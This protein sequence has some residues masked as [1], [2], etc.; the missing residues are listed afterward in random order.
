MSSISKQR[1][2]KNASFIISELIANGYNHF[3]IAPGSNS[4]PLTIAAHEHPLAKT[5]VHYDERSLGFFALGISKGGEKACVITTSGTA[6]CNLYPSIVEASQSNASLIILTAD[7]SYDLRDT[8]ANQTIDQVKMF[9]SYLRWETEISLSTGGLDEKVFRTTVDQACYRSR[10]GPVWINCPIQ[11]PGE[12]IDPDKDQSGRKPIAYTHYT[13]TEKA[14][15]EKSCIK[16]A[17][18][19]EK[20]E[21]GIIIVGAIEEAYDPLPILE[22]ATKLRWPVFADPTS[23]LRSIGSDLSKIDYYNFLIEAT[24]TGKEMKPRAVLHLGGPLVS[25]SLLEWLTSTDLKFYAQ[26]ADFP[27]RL[28]PFHKVSERIEM[29][30]ALFAKMLLP[31]LAEKELNRWAS[32]WKEYS[33]FTS[34]KIREYFEKEDHFCEANFIQ[35]LSEISMKQATLFLGASLPIRHTDQFFFPCKWMGGIFSNR[36]T[37]GI[38]GNLSTAAGIAIATKTHMTAVVGDLTFL[39]DVGALSLIRRYQIPLTVIVFNNAGGGIFEFLPIQKREEYFTNYYVDFPEESIEEIA[40]SYQILS[41]SADSLHAFETLLSEAHSL[42]AP[43]VIEIKTDRRESPE[44]YQDIREYLR[45]ALQKEEL[46]K[47]PWYFKKI[48]KKAPEETAQT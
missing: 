13:P 33:L 45:Q 12:S 26:V 44:V 30:P 42:A 48:R 32:L 11:N 39:H 10:S 23:K 14:L 46:G 38:D 1:N 7:R 29:K 35:K 18:M 6:V 19:F 40:K 36:G 15:D 31:Y 5:Y 25:K 47:S 2:E 28:D 4:T 27:R 3:C 17:E 22:L 43:F 34:A 21:R 37:S 8:L 9:G 41:R 16:L 24:P 20:E